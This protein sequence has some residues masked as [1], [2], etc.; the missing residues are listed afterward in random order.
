VGRTRELTQLKEKVLT[1]DAK[2]V[3]IVGGGVGIIGSAEIGKTQLAARLLH[4][5]QGSSSN[6]HLAAWESLRPSMGSGIPLSFENVLDS[7]L[8]TLSEGR[9][10]GAITAQD[11][12]RRRI[13][14]L[15]EFLSER[16]FLLVF[17]NIESVLSTASAERAGHFA[18]EQYAY[19]ELFTQLLEV[20]HQSKVIFTSR[21]TLA[22]LR[23][24]EYEPFVIGGLETVEAL[25]LLN[26][27]HLEASEEEL[28][29]LQI[30]TM[31]IR[32][33]CK[34]LRA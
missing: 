32:K 15:V 4:V 12:Y 23:R 8:G 31:V 28:V 20:E 18:P 27:F 29:T 7:L 3:G 26:S 33:H 1:P 9:I 30:D 14:R 6:F 34:S 11:D 19:A 13:R 21:E 16:P 2:A 10:T 24:P 17:D 25:D 22:D 5:I